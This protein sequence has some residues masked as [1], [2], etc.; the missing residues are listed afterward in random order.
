MLAGVLILVGS[1]QALTLFAVLAF[2]RA[3]DDSEMNR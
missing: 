1:A 2:C 3:G